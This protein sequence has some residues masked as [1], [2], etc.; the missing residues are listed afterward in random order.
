MQRRIAVKRLTASDL[1]LFEWQFKNRNAGNQKSINLNADVFIA[2][3]FPSLPE[4]A[5]ELNGRIPLDLNIYGPGHAGLHNLQRKVLKGSA[6]KNWRLDG[7]FITNPENEPER[8]NSLAPGDLAIFE[9]QGRIVPNSAKMVLI[10]QN[11]EV[12][13]P[14]YGEL[15]RIL[16]ERSMG[17]LSVAQLQ[18][19]V[20]KLEDDQHPF[21]ELTLDAELEDAVSGGTRGVAALQKRPATRALSREELQRARRIAEEVGRD[22]EELVCRYLIQQKKKGAISDFVWTSDTNAIAPYDFLVTMLD[23][24]EIEIDVKS[25]NGEFERTVHISCAELIETTGKRRYDIFRVF[26]VSETSGTLRI[27]E[28][29]GAFAAEVLKSLDRLPAGV[30]VDSLSIDVSAL[31]FG[32]AIPLTAP[33]AD[34]AEEI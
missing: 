10:S 32:P 4:A 13:R 24:E 3:L 19:I 23:K 27:A 9:F 7:E 28:N 8:Y 21:H 30:R 5:I 20:D 31:R 12:D 34:E 17:A 14:V 18:A 2:E 26:E 11:L 29:I 15:A 6:Y 33:V 1:T 22:G 25:T 16:G